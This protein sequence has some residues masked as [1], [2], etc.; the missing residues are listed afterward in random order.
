MLIDYKE[1]DI[2]WSIEAKINYYR[3]FSE[4]KKLAKNLKKLATF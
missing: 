4:L 1:D 2:K 3:S